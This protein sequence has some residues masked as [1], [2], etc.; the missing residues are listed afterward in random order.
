MVFEWIGNMNYAFR[1]F[2]HPHHSAW[3]PYWQWPCQKP[4]RY[5]AYCGWEPLVK[6]LG[7]SCPPTTTSI[8]IF[9]AGLATYAA[10]FTINLQKDP[11]PLYKTTTISIYRYL[12]QNTGVLSA[13][14]AE[15]GIW[16]IAW[17]LTRIAKIWYL[18]AKWDFCGTVEGS[19]W[20][21]SAISDAKIRNLGLRG[22]IGTTL[23]NFG[24]LV[25]NLGP[26]W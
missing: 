21:F 15:F 16:G 12:R 8:W 1:L 6:E 4:W 17:H 11:S 3:L 22:K 23:N 24:T 13:T 14:N 10:T 20:D 18:W 26:D 5:C 9:W 7:M 2:V 19:F 25:P